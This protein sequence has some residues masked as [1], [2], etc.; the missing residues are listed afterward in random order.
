MTDAIGA[1]RARVQLQSPV[2]APDDI[3]GAAISWGNEGEVWALI[4]ATSASEGVA[5]DTVP[6]T[7][8][9]RLTI[10]RRTDM[11]AGWR[12]LWGARVLRIAG[13]RDDGA[14]RFVLICEEEKL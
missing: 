4:E 13:I 11:R 10:N 14:P 1:M 2:R 6:A 12:V 9:F 8:N 5:F 7:A 3:G